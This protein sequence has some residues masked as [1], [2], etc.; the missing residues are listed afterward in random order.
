MIKCCTWELIAALFFIAFFCQ[1]SV[2]KEDTAQMSL[3][4]TVVSKQNVHLYKIKKGDVISAIIRRLPGIT[5]DDI[6]DNYRIIKELNPAI[7]DINKLYAGQLI[8]L[9]G[10]SIHS[11]EEEALLR[12]LQFQTPLPPRLH[13]IRL[14]EVI[15]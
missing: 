15:I 4:K 3:K 11:I 7:E 1:P 2:A 6:P 5:E 12:L 14:K 10:K 9:P 8:K 13:L